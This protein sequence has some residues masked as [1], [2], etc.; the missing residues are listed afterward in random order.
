M[1]CRI[2]IVNVERVKARC[3]YNRLRRISDTK[4][5]LPLPVVVREAF[6]PT[7][8]RRI[9]VARSKTFSTVGVSIDV[10]SHA[11]DDISYVAELH[12]DV[13]GSSYLLDVIIFDLRM[14]ANG[15]V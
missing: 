2:S 9:V 10:P 5:L 3:L 13:F 4:D 8:T 7:F 14:I 1:T 11:F 15:L 12:A 6:I